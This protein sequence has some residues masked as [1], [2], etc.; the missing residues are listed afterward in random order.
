VS[1]PWNIAHHPDSGLSQF[2][3]NRLHCHGNNLPSSRT[4]D[5]TR[6]FTV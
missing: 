6:E 2:L 4:Y 3:T 1:A 5:A